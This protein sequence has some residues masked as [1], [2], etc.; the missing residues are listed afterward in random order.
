MI[1]DC[2][3][4]YLLALNKLAA[5]NCSQLEK[6][7]KHTGSLENL[8][9]RSTK[10]LRQ[11]GLSEKKAEL[12]SMLSLD[13]IKVDLHWLEQTN[14]HIVCFDD[15]NYPPLLK[16]I[17]SPPLLLYI[18]GKP[19]LLL[20]PQI[21]I[22]G[23]RKPTPM[24]KENA[25]KF[26]QY[27]AKTGLTVTSGMALGIDAASH[28]GALETGA[29]IAVLG[30]GV[31]QAYPRQNLNLYKALIE[32]GAVISEFAIGTQPR[33]QHFPQ[34]NRIISGL[35]LGTLVI[36]AAIKSGSL[37]TAY[38]AA[39]Q[40][41]EVFA[42]PGSVHNPQSKGCHH[43]IKQGAA[44]V[45]KLDDV[46]FEIRHLWQFSKSKMF[47]KSLDLNQLDEDDTKILTCIGTETTSID[48][49]LS[50]SLLDPQKVTIA[51]TDLEINKLI[52][53]VPGGYSR[54]R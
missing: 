48:Q 42:L 29:S 38:L 28:W 43:L 49:I 19:E 5:I 1:A 33:R 31:D 10:Q 6:L 2:E 17:S 22:V 16:E 34:R 13:S 25:F 8:C 35:S 30:S 21:A 46:L 32:K 24:G 41:R 9:S 36:E 44:L 37:I 14:H 15:P 40:G 4:R 53:A 50:R 45:E 51:L 11:L 39:D 23:S 54:I 20:L 18:V 7:K 47:E 12:I 3:L 26:G 52:K 27:L